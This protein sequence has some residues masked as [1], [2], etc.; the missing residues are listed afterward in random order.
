MDGLGR[1]TLWL[2]VM[3]RVGE[4]VMAGRRRIQGPRALR[5]VGGVFLALAFAGFLACASLVWL[6]YRSPRSETADGVIVGFAYGPVIEFTTIDGVKSRL[7]STV[8]S[9]IWHVG[10]H[11][12]VAYA[13]GDPNDARIDGLA[14]RWFLP[15][16]F[17]IL[18]GVF[19]LVGG[20]LTFAGRR[21]SP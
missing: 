14:G 20:G 2:K 5:I 1:L 17:G 21:A 8:R 4:P 15:G 9:S 10:D 13:P 18:A 19:L 12:P 6:E 11:L 3:K 16:L 7:S